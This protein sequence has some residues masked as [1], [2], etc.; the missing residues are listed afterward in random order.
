LQ[1]TPVSKATDQAL[2]V[3]FK[4][5]PGGWVFRAPNPRVFGRSKH[6][7][8]D[9][10]QREEIVAIM[11]PRRPTLLLVA[12][13]VGF[14]LAVGAVAAALLLMMP[15][16]PVTVFVAVI[17]AAFLLAILALHL[18]ASRKLRRLQPILA[19]ASP[20]EQ[21][22][23]LAEI[24]QAVNRRFSYR[25]LL[26]SAITSAFACAVS[27]A[28][29]AVQAYFRKQHGSFLFEPLSLLF[30]CNAIMFGFLAAKHFRAAH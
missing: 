1:E 12:S 25:Q 15:D 7:L 26:L 23:T 27:V 13:I 9:D 10:A 2:A 16:Y 20:T 18:A 3:L 14:V 5:V 11:V 22:I 6:Y 8:V 17:L 24:Q 4:Q 29:L 28:T 19:G 21:Q 30:G